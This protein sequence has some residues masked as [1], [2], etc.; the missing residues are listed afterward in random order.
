MCHIF[1]AAMQ[2]STEP[3]K[4]WG[5]PTVGTPPAGGLARCMPSSTGN[6]QVSRDS[7][8][9]SWS[10]QGQRAQPPGDLRGLSN[11][12][13]MSVPSHGHGYAEPN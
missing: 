9:P 4:H 3:L 11:P 5:L 8:L 6:M 13:A 2:G 7:P 12:A 1:G 10:R